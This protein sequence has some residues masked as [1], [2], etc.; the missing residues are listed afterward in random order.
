[1]TPQDFPLAWPEDKPRTKVEDRQEAR[2]TVGF[3]EAYNCLV[4]E[5]EKLHDAKDFDVVISSNVP[6][7]DGGLPLVTAAKHLGDPG[8]AVYIWRGG[9]PFVLA[10]DSYR[11]VRH[12]LRAIWATIQSLRVISRHGTVQLLA[13][14][15]AGFAREVDGRPDV[16]RLAAQGG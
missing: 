12:N 10:C 11:E 3:K 4:H 5:A 15:M 8:V 1:M 6:V 13:Q 2:F 16:L 7:G 9:K 14:S